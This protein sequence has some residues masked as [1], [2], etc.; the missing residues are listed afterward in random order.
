[1]QYII[2]CQPKAEKIAV[3]EYRREDPDF[4]ILRW[5]EPGVGLAECALPPEELL[6]TIRR[7]PFIFTRH[8]VALEAE[9]PAE[10]FP[11]QEI[12]AVLQEKLP[13]G[14]PVSVQVRAQDP[15]RRKIV[16][17]VCGILDSL[18]LPQDRKN[19]SQTVS[20][21]ANG[22]AL[23]LGCG[24]AENNLSGWSGGEMH[25]S[26]REDFISRAEFKLLEAIDVFGV[27]T[28]K[29]Q[30]ALDLG[31]APGGWSAVLLRKGLC[32]DAVDP[33]E[34]HPDVARNPKLRHFREPVQRFLQR[35]PDRKYHLLVND[36][37]MDITKSAQLTASCA[38]LLYERA[39][40]LMTFKLPQKY[41]YND[42]KAGLAVLAE[43]YRLK[44]ARQ[45]FH[46]RDEITVL[47]EK[48]Y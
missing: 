28:E 24:P 14:E 19:G 38:P 35:K 17:E 44:D 30:S 39:V 6:L 45:L 36:M 47:L 12:S 32:V 16:D 29:M 26:K 37:K 10:P 42:I 7:T 21:Y 25:F 9:L 13:P 11:A 1:M 27:R 40:V 31:A 3:S 41:S 33:A 46:N 2:T 43:S 15:E 5:L 34:L 18:G 4:R 20:L 8:L 48:K 23:F 22:E